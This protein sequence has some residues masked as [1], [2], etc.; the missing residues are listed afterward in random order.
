[1][2]KIFF[3][4]VLSLFFLWNCKEMPNMSDPKDTVLPGMISNPV[5]ENINGGAIITYSLPDDNDLLGVKAV[6]SLTEDGEELEMFSSAFRDAIELNGFADTDEREVALICIDKS[7]NESSPV[8][9]KIN[10]LTPP[11]DLIRKTLK[12]N[13]AFGG[14]RATWDNIYNENIAL[15]LYVEDSLSPGYMTQYDTHYSSYPKGEVSFRGFDAIEKHFRIE[16]RDRWDNYA[17]PLE[18]TLTPLF[19]EEI[20]PYHPTSE[21]L[22]W[23]IAYG[24]FDDSRVWRGGFMQPQGGGW[25]ALFS[26]ARMSWGIVIDGEHIYTNNRWAVFQ[27]PLLVDY[28]PDSTEDP[29][30][31]NPAYF[32]FDLKD[33]IIPSR[34]VIYARS[35]GEVFPNSFEVWGTNSTPKGPEDFNNLTESLNYWTEWFLPPYVEGKDTWKEDWIKLGSYQVRPTPS[36]AYDDADLTE[37]DLTIRENGYEMEVDPDFVGTKVRYL[38]FVYRDVSSLYC[39]TTNINVYGQYVDRKW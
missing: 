38:R 30:Y 22:L 19:E 26:G 33:E 35:L 13:T 16:M 14:L 23:D 31:F 8:V 12:V 7:Y 36:G 39:Y 17:E 29:T 27:K 11:V 37:E 25:T 32:I 15:T 2:K 1:M 5:V 4:I 3:L 24:A 28:F 20:L 10:P 18:F 21:E 6:Y 9:V 34:V